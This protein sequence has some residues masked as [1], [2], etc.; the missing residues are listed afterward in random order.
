MFDMLKLPTR[1]L[2]QKSPVATSSRLRLQ[3]PFETLKFAFLFAQETLLIRSGDA[4]AQ[5]LNP[6]GKTS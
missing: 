2:V 3:F 5:V 1:L 6:H 4:L